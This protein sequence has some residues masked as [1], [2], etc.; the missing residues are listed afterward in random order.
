[1]FSLVEGRSAMVQAVLLRNR[2]DLDD[3]MPMPSRRNT[4]GMKQEYS[5]SPS[6]SFD[7]SSLESGGGSRTTTPQ[8]PT[9]VRD[10]NYYLC[11]YFSCF[12][13]SDLSFSL[14]SFICLFLSHFFL[15]QSPPPTMPKPAS[16]SRRQHLAVPQQQQPSRQPE[17]IN[18]LH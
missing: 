7:V 4:G 11:N 13:F 1:M 18:I 12:I 3:N 16:S 2:H 6:N 15:L 5:I 10:N 9:T 17:G 8:Q 14:L